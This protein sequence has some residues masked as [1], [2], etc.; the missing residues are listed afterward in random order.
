MQA[1]SDPHTDLKV[2]YDRN[3]KVLTD[4]N[5]K[6]TDIGVYLKPF[7]QFRGTLAKRRAKEKP[8]LPQTIQTVRSTGEYRLA[9]EHS[10]FLQYEN[11]NDNNR[12]I[13]FMSLFAIEWLRSCICIHGDGTF[14]RMSRLVFSIFYVLF[15]AF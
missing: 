11:L 1:L 6:L 15:G 3:V 14:K 13:I 2:I 9:N 5:Y 7:I 8:P 10:P 12:V 4:Q